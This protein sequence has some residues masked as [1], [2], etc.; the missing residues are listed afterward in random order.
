MSASVR[1]LVC[2]C[3]VSAFAAGR[4]IAAP[5]P[6][7]D[8]YRGEAMITFASARCAELATPVAV[9]DT[10]TLYYRPAFDGVVSVIVFTHDLGAF[11]LGRVGDFVGEGDAQADAISRML[12]VTEQYRPSAFAGMTAFPLPGDTKPYPPYVRVAGRIKGFFDDHVNQGCTVAFRA[13]VNFRAANEGIV[14]PGPG[15]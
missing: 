5:A 12:L 8:H 15:G 7:E 2:V 6:L 9:G 1:V 14:D 3:I 13:G 10:F 4:S 11:R